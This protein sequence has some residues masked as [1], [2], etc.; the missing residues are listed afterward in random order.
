MLPITKRGKFDRE[1]SL[2]ASCIEKRVCEC[3]L[4]GVW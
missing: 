2:Y 3:P 4:S 1:D